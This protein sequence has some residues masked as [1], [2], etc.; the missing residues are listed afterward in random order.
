MQ[1]GRGSNDDASRIEEAAAALR[2]IGNEIDG[3]TVSV[4]PSALAK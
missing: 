4:S 3:G 2:G 1:L